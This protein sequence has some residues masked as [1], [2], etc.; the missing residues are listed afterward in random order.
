MAKVM[1][2]ARRG[3]VVRGMGAEVLT[4]R[5]AAGAA[6]ALGLLG[7]VPGFAQQA[8]DTTYMRVTNQVILASVT[9]LGINLG[10]QDFY[11]SGQMLRNL[12]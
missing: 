2:H 5:I 11:D 9:R 7:C 4:S 10:D 1:I 6:F 3:K 12:I 8:G